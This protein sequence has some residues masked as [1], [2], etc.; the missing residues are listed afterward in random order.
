MDIEV[1]AFEL[2]D[3]DGR[4]CIGPLSLRLEGGS[5]CAILGATGAGKSRFLRGLSGLNPPGWKIRGTLRL[6]GAT[7][8]DPAA[9][10]VVLLPQDPM[11]A[12]NPWMSVREHLALLPRAWS[13]PGGWERAAALAERLGLRDE[14]GLWS[15]RPEALSGGQRQRLLMAMLL[16]GRPE[17]L[18]LDEPTAALDP[19]RVH[20]FGEILEA[21]RRELGMGWIWVTHQPQLAQRHADRVICMAHGQRVQEV[22]GAESGLRNGLFQRFLRAATWP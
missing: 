13:L 2:L 19:A 11:E 9:P 4:R 22:G 15:R 3:A 21:L 16:S 7:W 1:D 10:R 14:G 17:W 18:L 6:G 5:R 8:P 20:T 12:L